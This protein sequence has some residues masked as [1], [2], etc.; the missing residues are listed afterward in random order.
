M[1]RCVC[2]DGQGFSDEFYKDPTI[3]Q[4]AE[5]SDYNLSLSDLDLFFKRLKVVFEYEKRAETETFSVCSELWGM[6]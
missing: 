3:L 1:T 6:F 2:F 5:L 4:K